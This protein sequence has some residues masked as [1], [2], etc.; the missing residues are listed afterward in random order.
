MEPARYAIGNA[1]IEM[2]A[3]V[4]IPVDYV[5]KSLIDKGALKNVNSGRFGRMYFNWH[6]KF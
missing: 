2:S 5:M 4:K 1:N 3:K 6:L